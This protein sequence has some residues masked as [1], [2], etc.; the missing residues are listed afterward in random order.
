[1]PGAVLAFEAAAMCCRLHLPVDAGDHISG[2]GD[3]PVTLVMYGDYEC[4][5]SGTAYS[6][7]LTVQRALKG[8]LRFVFRHF[9]QPNLHPHAEDAAEVAEMAADRGRF[10]QLHDTF[11]DHQNAL[12]HDHL[13]QYAVGVGLDVAWVTPLLHLHA[14]AERVRRDFLSGVQ[15][16]VS[17]TPTFFINEARYDGSLDVAS[18][19]VALQDAFY[20]MR[21]AILLGADTGSRVRRGGREESDARKRVVCA[22]RADR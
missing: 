3:A 13:L 5:W 21:R 17:C 7:A 10:W 19:V 20:V 6:L 14:R 8:R 11:Y 4:R 18:L 2:A 22:A 9:P 12:D 1:M 16:G 15:S